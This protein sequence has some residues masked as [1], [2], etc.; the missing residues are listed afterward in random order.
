M[1]RRWREILEGTYDVAKRM[2]WKYDNC[3]VLG[4]LRV[5]LV[6]AK[7]RNYCPAAFSGFNEP[8][9]MGIM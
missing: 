8:S 3:C 9:L 2:S 1:D 4:A 6:N 5:R 7:I